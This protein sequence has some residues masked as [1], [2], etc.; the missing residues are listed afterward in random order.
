MHQKIYVK[1]A[2][3]V[4]KHVIHLINAYLVAIRIYIMDNAFKI[5]HLVL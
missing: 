4:A 3:V 2:I 5:A 1:F